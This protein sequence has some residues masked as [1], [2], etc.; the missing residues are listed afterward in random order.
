MRQ[1]F[2]H[3][4]HRLA[5]HVDHHQAGEQAGKQRDDQNRL[6]RFK[7]LRQPRITADRLGAVTGN[8]T[9]ND[10]ANKTSPQGARQ[11]AANHPRRQAWTV[12]NRVGD[13]TRQ[14][15]HHQFKGRIPA[16]L[17]Q[18]RS[19]GARFFI[20]GNA[21]H[22]GQRD[23][24]A[25]RHHHRQH[26]RHTGQQV[27]V[28]AGF[29]LLGR[30]RTARCRALL[31]TFGQGFFQRGFGLLKRNAG[32]ATVDFLARKALSRDF[33]ISRQQHHV[34]V[35]DGLGTQRVAGANRALGLDLQVVAQALGRLLQGFCRHKGVRHARRAG[36]HGNNFRRVGLLG[37]LSLN[38]GGGVHLGFVDATQ[39]HGFN[40]L[41]GL[42]RAA[43]EDPF[44][45]KTLHVQRRAADHQH[46]LGFVDGRLGQ[47][48]FRVLGVMH[49][50]AG[51]PALTL[52]GGIEQ[53]GT[54][55]AGHHAVGAARHN[56]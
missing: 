40:I 8:K 34:R 28:N 7:A 43:L 19:Q 31:P 24:Q 54:Q 30:C 13:V 1:A 18:R 33:N 15:R 4:G 26:E 20:S 12:G 48:T 53:A 10:P 5:D 52:R 21:K 36:S 39:Q 27:F 17:H 29:L 56:G 47:L 50:Y 44:A 51:A 6:Q 38:A 49:F 41:Q 11:Q 23:Q 32:A 16:D 46:P 42:G 3:A 14:Q 37:N 22:K 2:E 9:G 35:A 25:A 55:H 45:N